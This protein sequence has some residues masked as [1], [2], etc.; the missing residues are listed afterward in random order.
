MGDAPKKPIAMMTWEQVENLSR[1]EMLAGIRA[2]LLETMEL[3][4]RA[5]NAEYALYDHLRRDGA[6]PKTAEE[7]S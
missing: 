2:L 1:E 5:Q 6:L 4:L 3:R 7:R